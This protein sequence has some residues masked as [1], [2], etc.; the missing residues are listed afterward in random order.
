MRTKVPYQPLP[1]LFVA[2]VLG[3][4]ADRFLAPSALFWGLFVFAALAVWFATSRFRSVETQGIASRRGVG[5]A[6]VRPFALLVACAA[7]FGF[8]HH[9]HWYRFAENNIGC[10][11]A[12]IAAEYGFDGGTQP[13]ALIGTVVEMPRFYPK[14]P[15][16]PGQIFESSEKTL[17]TLRSEQLR[18]GSD[19]IPVS[20][21]VMVTV[22]D[23]SRHF[24][25]GDRLQLFGELVQPPKPGN[26]GDY[27][28]YEYFRG[29]RILALLRC[30]GN[31]SV[32]L[33]SSH[34]LSPGRWLESVRRNGL[35]NLRQH[36]SPQTLAVAEAMIFGVRES[37]DDEVRQNMLDTGTMHL[38]SISG[39]HV[40]L[41]A[42]LAAWFLR[43]LRFSRR[44]AAVSM[45]V[46]VLFYLFLTDVRPP[47]IRAT[48][49]TC[50]FAIALYVNRLTLAVNL[51][52]A[53][54][55]VVLF[56]NPSELFQFGAQLSF[57][58]M[59]SFLWIPRYTRLLSLLN[60]SNTASGDSQ[61]LNDIERVETTSWRWLRRFGQMCRWSVELFLISLTIWLFATPIL[62]QNIHLF[63]PVAILVNPLLWLPLTA[64]MSCGFITAMIGQVPLL[65]SVF[66]FGTDWSFWML[67]EMI[68]W[69]QRLGG[70]Y[71]V[72]GPPGWWNLGF[73]AVFAFFTFL[74]IR[75]PHW[76]ILLTALLV[77]ILIGVGAG[78]YR[79]AE[80]LRSDRLTLSVLS[81]GHGN[82]VL[83]VTPEKRTI[84]CD[85]GCLTS[86]RYA[87]DVMSRSLWRLGKTHID[88]ILL[89]H[90]DNDHFNG[91]PLLADR[92]SIGAVLISPYTS[93]IQSE[94]DQAAWSLLM[95]TLEAKR[96]PVRIVGEGDDLSEYGLP[97]SIILHPPKEG[98]EEQHMTNA[99]SLV[100]RFEHRGV[101]IL[102]PGDLDGRTIS[103]FLLREPMPTAIVMVP[104]HGGRSQQ[105]ERLLEWTTPQTLIFSNGK[106]TYKPEVLEQLRGQGYEVRSTFVEGAIVIDIEK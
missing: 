38:L 75:R 60:P 41:I 12:G 45:I 5:L 25:I 29:H 46:F 73:Y 2:A 34:R 56:A 95:A 97:E 92:F 66:G 59:G 96:I 44:T 93:E 16:F 15:S 80:R 4:L 85:V 3:I 10:Y 32:S 74:P 8:W 28:Y 47:A 104:H 14:R 67:L 26:P 27:N 57:I 39:L 19:W 33:L 43:L 94:S 106:L 70:H 68:A 35:A 79:D 89:S 21:K 37:V 76:S 63:T 98:F 42:G 61:K 65:G 101:G 31:V 86:P 22:Y 81:I 64:A 1:P 36:L 17:F 55:L 11:A 84:I 102:L 9:V 88:A 30:P 82:S 7:F 99:A 49:L 105:A 50:S 6:I 77:W 52:C 103:P 58:A 69:F 51:L 40:T 48:A 87:A 83:I 91:V 13:V 53:S 78:Y 71:W 62:T 100:L 18:D 54:A 72:P 23:D 90:P 24:R 20:G